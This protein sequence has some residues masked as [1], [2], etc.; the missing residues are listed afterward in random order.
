M[1]GIIVFLSDNPGSITYSDLIANNGSGVQENLGI[2]NIHITYNS[3][4]YPQ[5]YEF[6]FTDVRGAALMMP[7][8]RKL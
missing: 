1:K 4:H 5:G 8:E 7:H 2:T 3:Y 6:H